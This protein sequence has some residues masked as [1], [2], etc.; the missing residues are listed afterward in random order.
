MIPLLLIR[1][2]KTEWNLQKKLQGRQDISLCEVGITEL[3]QMSLPTEF[4]HFEWCV[5]PLKRAQETAKL[6]G[7]ENFATDD[8]L[9]EMDF[10]EWEGCTIKALRER[11]GQS[12]L[13]NEAKGIY[14][15]PPQGES[16]YDVQQRLRS[17]LRGLRNPTIAV[18][19]KGVI[20]A[21]KSLAYDWDMKDK[22][23]MEFKWNA[24]HLFEVTSEGIPVGKKLNIKLDAAK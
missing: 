23:P 20:R 21:I 2:G 19:H 15:T 12:M 1:H 3:K 16:P 22:F 4:N 24:A 13:D 11:Y 18:T 8:R 10:G 14:M 17:F 5:S 7:A 6:L 9:I